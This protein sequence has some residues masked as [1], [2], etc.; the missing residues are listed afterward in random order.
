MANHKVEVSHWTQ[1]TKSELPSGNAMW[2]I[3]N[4]HDAR[5]QIRFIINSYS[6]KGGR[7]IVKHNGRV[8]YDSVSPPKKV[9]TGTT[10]G[11]GTIIK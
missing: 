7:F 11:N 9:E 2:N 6:K 5:D 3:N 1:H 8:V 4:I 10:R